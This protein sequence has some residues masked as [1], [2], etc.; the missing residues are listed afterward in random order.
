MDSGD[1]W[2]I[3]VGGVAI[4]VSIFAVVSAKRTARDQA[5]LSL[6]QT[7]LNE[8]LVQIE[9]DRRQEEVTSRQAANVA[10]QIV[11]KG[12][13]S[14]SLV[15][16]NYGPSSAHQVDIDCAVIDSVK[17]ERDKLPVDVLGPGD[18]VDLLVVVSRETIGSHP[19]VLKWTD[20]TGPQTRDGTL[21]I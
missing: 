6:D 19:Y 8:R 18:N 15:F 4:L 11:P 20:E 9:E 7:K 17:G 13:N 3:A 14:R 2:S 1:V 10:V 5:S 16:T 12:A 21:S